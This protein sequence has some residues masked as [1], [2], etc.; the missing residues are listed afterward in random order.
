MEISD[1]HM[2]L[3]QQRNTRISDV[4]NQSCHTFLWKTD[5]GIRAQGFMKYVMMHAHNTLTLLMWCDGTH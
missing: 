1:H 3:E 4:K 2:R 5:H